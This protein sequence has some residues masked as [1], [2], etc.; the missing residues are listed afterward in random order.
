M[1][2]APSGGRAMSRRRGPVFLPPG[3]Y[4]LRRRR[5]AALLLPFV[6]ALLFLL[7]LFWGGSGGPGTARI[8]LYLFAVWA[9]L[10][11]VA[12]LLSPRLEDPR[13]RQAED[14]GEP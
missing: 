9:A 1:P 11:L 5:D 4:R 2:A 12:A 6:G 8:G 10:I 7:P 14:E 3:G 13:A